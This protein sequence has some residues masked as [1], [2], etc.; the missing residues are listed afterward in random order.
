[1]LKEVREAEETLHNAFIKLKDEA[2]D[3]T[4]MFERASFR[5]KLTAE[6]TQALEKLKKHLKEAEEEV[7]KEIE[8]IEDINLKG[9]TVNMKKIRVENLDK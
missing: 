5:R 4:T 6:E 8:D 2:K 9:T 3:I 1:M 7:R